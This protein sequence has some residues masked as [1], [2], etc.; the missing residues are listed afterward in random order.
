MEVLL[1]TRGERRVKCLLLLYL[2]VMKA[3]ANCPTPQG[4]PNIVLTDASLLKNDFP[5][6]SEVT[7]ECAKGYVTESGS[8]IIKCIDGNWTESDLTCKRKDC[9]PPTPQPNMSFNTSAG[10][11]F[12]AVIRVVCDKG[13]QIRGSSFKQCYAAG[14][15]RRAAKCEIVTCDKPSDV[16]NGRNSWDSHNFPKYGDIVQY[17]CNEGHTLIGKDS[18]MCR[19][20][21]K[22]DS[23]PPECQGV[24]TEGRIT[25]KMATPTSTPPAQEASTSTDSSATPTAHRDKTITTTTAP[26]VLPSVQE[27]STS[28]D[29]SATPTA[30]RDKTITTTTAP[31]VI[32]SV[33]G[34]RDILSAKD[35]ATTTS[36]TSSSSQD[37]HY[38]AVDTNKDIG[39]TPAIISLIVILLGVS[40]VFGL[41]KLL[42][43]KKGSANGTAPIC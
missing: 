16:T 23:Q 39:Y 15:S 25:T 36:V 24:T 6:G 21:G 1:D 12:G 7:L 38:G 34:G 4:R 9:G 27:A 30:H 41:Y 5:E 42:L 13:Y 18:I 19:E 26:T 17:I 35:N 31:T 20:T 8:D 28:T 22:Y 40:I 37:K 2:L 43:K 14:W 11:L 32:P 10:T 33:Q 29:S 3:A